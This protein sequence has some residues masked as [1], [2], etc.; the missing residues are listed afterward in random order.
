MELIRNTIRVG[1]SAGVLLPKEWLNSQVRVEI[2]SKKPI[3]ILV[4]VINI[5]ENEGIFSDILGI[6]LTGSYARNEETPESDIDILVITDNINRSVK[7]GIYELLVISKDNLI[8]LLNKNIMPLLPMLVESKSLL[9]QELLEELKKTKINK[10]NLEWHINTTKESIKKSKSLIEI[11]K[12]LRDSK[13]SD[14]I[15]YSLVLRMRG[16]YII[17]C[18]KK[19]KLWSNKELVNLI[20]KITGSSLIYERYNHIKNEKGEDQEKLPLTEAEKLILYIEEKNKEQEK[21]L[22]ELKD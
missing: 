1:N 17:D 2:I 20:E 19:N 16:I 22:K 7:R 18:L 10:K 12:K 4:D 21:W 3:D 13:I 9:N 5:L 11:R 8:R 6:Y 14:G 15:A